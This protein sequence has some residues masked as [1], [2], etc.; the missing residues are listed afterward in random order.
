MS[1]KRQTAIAPSWTSKPLHNTIPAY[2]KAPTPMRLRIRE[3]CNT[4]R[5]PIPDSRTPKRIHIQILTAASVNNVKT[6]FQIR[7]CSKKVSIQVYTREPPKHVEV[8][9]ETPVWR[10][11][12]QMRLHTR[13]PQN[14]ITIWF[15]TRVCQKHVKKQVSLLPPPK[16]KQTRQH[17]I[18]TQCMTQYVKLRLHTR[19]PPNPFKM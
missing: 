18:P 7:V 6:L 19:E 11:Q 17:T 2:G 9:L 14:L 3:P 4:C 16:K 5:T 1:T 10:K 12:L 8:G 15:Q 13:E